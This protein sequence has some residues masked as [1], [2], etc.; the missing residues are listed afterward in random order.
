MARHENA[1]AVTVS[2]FLTGTRH[3]AAIL[4]K[5]A[6]CRCGCNG[7]CSMHALFLFL[8]WIFE[9]M[10]SG[11]HPTC[12]HDGKPWKA[13]S[14]DGRAIVSG[15]NLGWIG[16]LV[17]IRLDWAE[18]ANTFGFYTWSHTLHPCLLCYT[19]LARLFT[20]SGL[21][22][23]SMPSPL[24]TQ[25]EYGAVCTASEINAEIRTQSDLNRLKGMFHYRVRGHGGRCMRVDSDYFGLLADARLEP[26]PTTPDIGAIDTM[27]P[28]FQLVFWRD[29]GL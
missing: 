25:P 28:P 17:G 5:S 6:Q 20:S 24:K 11:R 19:V 4:R 7:W 18:M 8:N 2:I 10:V 3:M 27:V 9:A 29:L 14:D 15:S 1:I 16:I 13:G 26:S 23:L 21:S 22:R 12:R